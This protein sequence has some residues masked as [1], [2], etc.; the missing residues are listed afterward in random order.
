MGKPEKEK[1]KSPKPEKEKVKSSEI[2]DNRYVVQSVAANPLKIKLKTG[3]FGSDLDM[4]KAPLKLKV[5]LKD[6]S[7]SGELS[8]GITKKKK[9]KKKKQRTRSPSSDR[10]DTS[11]PIILR[12][13]SP[14]NK[15]PEEPTAAVVK[16]EKIKVTKAIDGKPSGSG[17]N[18][19]Y[20]V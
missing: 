15:R 11:K 9:H 8:G 17:G 16:V 2:N 14:T 18:N 1:V 7:S 3:S 20:L 6:C 4:V 12:I 5:S 19:G 10:Q 13:K